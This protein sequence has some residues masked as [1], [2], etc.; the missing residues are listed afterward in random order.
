MFQSSCGIGFQPLFCCPNIARKLYSDKRACPRRVLDIDDLSWSRA[1]SGFFNSEIS[2]L[3]LCD[4]HSTLFSGFPTT[5]YFLWL[6]PELKNR[7][8]KAPLR[9]HMTRCGNPF[10]EGVKTGFCPLP[11]NDQLFPWV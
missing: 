10:D 5:F 7:N 8:Y 4:P 3:T 6:S 11:G 1:A 9:E 2:G